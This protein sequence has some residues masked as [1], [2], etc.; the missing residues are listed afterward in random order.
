MVDNQKNECP[1]YHRGKCRPSKLVSE[2]TYTRQLSSVEAEAGHDARDF[3]AVGD[4][5]AR[6]PIVDPLVRDHHLASFP[7]STL[8]SCLL[9]SPPTGLWADLVR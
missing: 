4:D 1:A 6:N 2:K 5:E 7:T 3:A 8:E 9:M